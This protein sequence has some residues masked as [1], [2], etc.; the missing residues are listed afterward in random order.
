M[1][2]CLVSFSNV[3][4]L[5]Y[6][7]KYI[8]SIVAA[9]N[10]CD[11]L[12]WD[13]EALDG[14]REAM[15]GCRVRCY[16]RKITPDSG[17]FEKVKGYYGASLLFNKVLKNEHYDRVAFLETHSAVACA[18]RLLDEY[19]GRFIVEVRDFTYENNFLYRTVESR[20]L[21]D[22]LARVV[23][24]DAY[25]SFLPEGDY[26]LAHNIDYF[27][28][29]A[30][31]RFYRARRNGPPYRISFVGTIR[32]VDINKA[33]IDNFGN[34]PL[35]ELGYFGMGSEVLERYCRSKNITNVF[36]GPAFSQDET[37]LQ[38]RDA[39]LVNNV[40]GNKDP[41][42]D[43]ALSNKLYHAAQLHL[44]ICVS[45]GT[46]ME[47]VACTYGFGFPLDPF[48]SDTPSKLLAWL[49]GL[50]RR[51]M[52]KGCEDFLASVRSENEAYIDMIESFSAG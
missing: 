12:F 18:R 19:K 22:A 6:A 15:L 44:P 11:L 3:N 10:D 28:D 31:S 26:V 52:E 27:A 24:S 21:S 50:D 23:S 2:Y 45:P 9:G 38:Y 35:F 34:H 40:Y 25:K 47:E 17:A 29:D 42:L 30:L 49:E 37:L 41:H 1:K 20:V 36:F 51:E 48:D 39:S 32:F 13:K 14:E 43:Y 5:P 4:V 8:D 46:Y 33:I 7:R 16:N